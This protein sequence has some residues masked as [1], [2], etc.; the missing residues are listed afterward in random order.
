MIKPGVSLQSAPNRT[1]EELKLNE[2]A[3]AGTSLQTPNR[4]LEELKPVL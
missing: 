3:W 4:T 2:P 1:L